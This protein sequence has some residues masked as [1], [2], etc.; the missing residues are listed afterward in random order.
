MTRLECCR[1][2]AYDGSSQT[3]VHGPTCSTPDQLLSDEEFARWRA[4]GRARASAFNRDAESRALARAA[5][6]T[7]AMDDH[8]AGKGPRYRASQ[9]WIKCSC[10]IPMAEYCK[11]HGGHL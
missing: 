1:P 5:A 7:Q 6:R 2:T 8:P 11:V 4:D 9:L 3:L 10:H